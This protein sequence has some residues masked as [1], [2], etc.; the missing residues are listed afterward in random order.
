[1]LLNNGV[2]FRAHDFVKIVIYVKLK[3]LLTVISKKC[4][5]EKLLFI[6]WSSE[7]QN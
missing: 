1:M 7:T 3:Y 4:Y 6:M 5:N 2:C